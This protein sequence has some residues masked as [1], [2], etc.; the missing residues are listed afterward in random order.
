MRAK[1]RIPRAALYCRIEQEK[2]DSNIND[3]NDC[4]VVAVAAVCGVSYKEAHE[5]FAAHG[6][7]QR[8]GVRHGTTGAVVRSFG[9]ELRKVDLQEMID[10][11]P[12]AHKK[13]L[14]VTTHHP[15]RFNSVWADGKR[16]L[17]TTRGHV[18]AVVDGRNCDWTKGRAMRVLWAYEVIPPQK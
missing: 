8:K 10:R 1:S 5:A 3:T 12:G 2:E 18:L 15:E 4:A 17:F 6:R 9:F 7:K 14:N 11:Y 16:Y 13:L